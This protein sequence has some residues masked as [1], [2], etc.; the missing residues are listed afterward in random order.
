MPNCH[1][2]AVHPNG[3]RLAVTATNGGSNGNG[4]QLDKSG[5]YPGNW[6]PVH[7]WEMQAGMTNV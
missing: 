5:E 2:L 1:S 4:R 6:S 3:R 7:I